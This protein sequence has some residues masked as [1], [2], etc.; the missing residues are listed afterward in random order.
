M[1]K[2]AFLNYADMKRMATLA[3]REGVIV[4]VEIDGKIVRI[5]PDR[6]DKR[7]ELDEPFEEIRL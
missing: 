6:G 7:E 5:K 3:K 2:P 4:E 1:T